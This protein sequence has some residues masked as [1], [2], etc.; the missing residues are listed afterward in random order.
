MRR[1]VHDL[2]VV[3]GAASLEVDDRGE[4]GALF[5][6]LAL[7]SS[8]N[9]RSEPKLPIK[10]HTIGDKTFFFCFGLCN[11]TNLSEMRKP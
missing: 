10:I 11:K 1:G 3:G 9:R 5:R 2:P 8:K 4:D 7:K 6:P